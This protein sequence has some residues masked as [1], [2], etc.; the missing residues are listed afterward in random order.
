MSTGILCTILFLSNFGAN[1]FTKKSSNIV[2]TGHKK[3]SLFLL[4]NS[5]VACLFFWLS[6]G[7]RL[8]MNLRTFCYS[9]IFATVV[10]A[11]L[12]LSLYVYC[13]ISV[14][15]VT[16]VRNAGTLV[17]CS[18]V[19][20]ILFQ[21]NFVAMDFLRILLLIGA[22]LLFAISS[23]DSH[24]TNNKKGIWA[25]IL[26]TLASS[27]TVI[28]QKYYAAD[29][30]VTD[31]NSFFFFT[32]AILMISS[33]PW[34][35]LENR[36]SKFM[37]EKQQRKTFPLAFIGNTICSNI[38]SWVTVLLLQTMAVSLY[39][40]LSIAFGIVSGV[41]ASF[42]FREKVDFWVLSAAALSI[43]AVII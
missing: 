23:K 14:A 32:N 19:G 37:K 8:H 16:V 4:A 28:V 39:T 9:A 11:T 17:L 41:A 40:P 3:Y 18:A 21:E 42:V 7:L 13:F 12:I 29:T 34:L 6:N 10:F 22:I 33:F 25:L 31:E 38:G 27:A 1:I 15:G 5:V 30:H 26:L 36:N 35:I 20:T 24:G 43:V 2:A